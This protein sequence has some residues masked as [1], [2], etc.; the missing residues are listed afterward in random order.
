MFF[1]QIIYRCYKV[2][3]KHKSKKEKIFT[4]TNATLDK[5]N[6]KPNI[7]N[8]WECFKRCAGLFK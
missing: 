4:Y 7:L 8:G 6:S 5:G 3:P 1:F 2:I